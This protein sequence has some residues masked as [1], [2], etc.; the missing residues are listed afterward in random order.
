MPTQ[1]SV[2]IPFE[3]RLSRLD[4]LIKQNHGNQRIYFEILDADRNVVATAADD[5]LV[6][7]NL[8]P[9]RYYFRI[10]GGVSKAVDFTIRCTQMN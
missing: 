7:Q 6:L 9:G 10:R 1:A 2:E 4:A 5:E 8:S 3:V